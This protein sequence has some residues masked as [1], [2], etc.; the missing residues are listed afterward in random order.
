MFG[1]ALT[2]VVPS[3]SRE[4]LRHGPSVAALREAAERSAADCRVALDY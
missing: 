4:I 2:N 1:D 3:M